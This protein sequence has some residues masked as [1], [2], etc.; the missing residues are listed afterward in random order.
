M[1]MLLPV[2]I[3]RTVSCAV[4]VRG[5]SVSRV[6]MV[7]RLSNSVTTYVLYMQ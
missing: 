4:G 1:A 7:S 5:L 3:S 2:E 6:Y